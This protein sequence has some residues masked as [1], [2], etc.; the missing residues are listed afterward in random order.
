VIV[1]SSLITPAPLEFPTVNDPPIVTPLF[2]ARLTPVLF[3]LI[4]GLFDP[5]ISVFVFTPSTPL[6]RTVES[7]EPFPIQRVP[8][9]S[10]ND[11]PVQVFEPL[12]EESAPKK[13]T[14]DPFPLLEYATSPAVFVIA[15][16]K[17]VFAALL[18]TID[19]LSVPVPNVI[20][21]LNDRTR[22]SELAD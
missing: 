17:L 5:I 21:P 12:L 10:V 20:G 6:P 14:P 15:T 7:P 2:I 11:P 4:I 13:I 19:T 1:P 18:P 22:F 8:E 16:M 9:L 3:V